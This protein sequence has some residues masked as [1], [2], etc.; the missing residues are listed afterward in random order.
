MHLIKYTELAL[1]FAHPGGMTNKFESVVIFESVV[2]YHTNIQK[3]F[4]YF[5]FY[6]SLILRKQLFYN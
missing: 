6:P 1:H 2:S 5:D 4:F 3:L